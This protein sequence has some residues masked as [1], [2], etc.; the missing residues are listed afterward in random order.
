VRAAHVQGVNDFTDRT[1]AELARMR[2]VAPARLPSVAAADALAA[3]RKAGAPLPL[4]S[5]DAP[6]HLDWRMRGVVTAVKNQGGC[7]SCWAFAATEAVESAFAVASGRL[8]VLSPQQVL[9]CTPNPSECGGDGGCTGGTPELAFASLMSAGGLSSEWTYP[10]TSFHGGDVGACRFDATATPPVARVDGFVTL[11]R[12]SYWPVLS[13]LS[14]QGPLAV[15]VDASA[16]FDYES[17]I[18]TG[19]AKDTP[20]IDHAVTLVGY[21]T[22]A[23]TG[24]AY[25]LIRNSWGTRWGEAGYMR[26]ARAGPDNVAC[27]SDVTPFDGSDCKNVSNPVQSVT[28]CGECGILYDVSYPHVTPYGGFGDAAAAAAVM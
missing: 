2:G 5:A 14:V 13:A 11:P 20:D 24:A 9:E 12:N 19:C 15:N 3:P 18:F 7:G 8:E 23:G 21:G 25:W 16:W 26:L 28:V 27:A 1:D 22:D 10:Y 4:L 17:G 6:P